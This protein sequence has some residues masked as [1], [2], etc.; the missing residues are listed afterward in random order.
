MREMAVLSSHGDD[1]V[2]KALQSS[3][4]LLLTG[5]PILEPIQGHGFF[6]MNNCEEILE[7]YHDLE[8]GNFIR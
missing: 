4:F 1:V 6:V 7:A 3:R 8:H 5:Q 2:I